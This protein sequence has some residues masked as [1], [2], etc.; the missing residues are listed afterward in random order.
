MEIAT[1]TPEERT[2][3]NILD[4]IIDVSKPI[5]FK[6]FVY[7]EFIQWNDELEELKTSLIKSDGQIDTNNKK[8]SKRYLEL[9]K[10][11]NDC[12]V[13]RDE[14]LI[15]TI[16]KVQEIATDEGYS[17]YKRDGGIYTYNGEFWI[18]I[19]SEEFT[20]FLSDFAEKIGVPP[21]YAKHHRFREELLK[22]F[23]LTHYL[24]YSL[25]DSDNVVINLSN[26]AFEITPFGQK[27][28]EF[29]KED[30]LKYK[31]SFDYNPS[32]KAPVFQ[33]YLD[34]VLPHEDVQRLF[35]ETIAYAFTR[36][37]AA[38]FEKVV[39]LYGQG[40]NGKS[41]ALDLIQDLI[42]K[43]NVSNFS[44]T[45]LTD[46]AGYT[47]AKIG[48]KLMNIAS[49]ISGNLENDHFKLLSSGE[50][51]EARNPYGEPFTIHDYC[52]FMFACNELPKSV[53]H[54]DGYHRR[55]LVIPFDV[56]IP[57]NERDVDL[58]NKIVNAGEL[59]GIFNLILEGLERILKQRKFSFCEQVDDV[60]A[61]FK[62]ESNSV[63]MFID[64][65]NLERSIT[66]YK[67]IAEL[68]PQYKRYCDS[69]GCKWFTRLNFKKE[70]IKNNVVVKKQS[71]G[72]VAYLNVKMEGEINDF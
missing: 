49:E 51:I 34:R 13:K 67:P 32:A 9:T 62:K 71:I 2:S 23:L 41:V 55:F 61:K 63:L 12:K 59:S 29:R 5:D 56:Q 27:L 31:L 8:G 17:L 28:R 46:K 24:R 30:F 44:L 14:Y 66:D 58:K 42:G 25:H 38:K 52:R 43:Q 37:S 40:A 68:Y 53:E 18:E 3:T 7:P 33:K 1:A 69:A 35:F 16:D 65:C 26:G 4:S 21:I 54:S 48:D 36:N 15:Y 6:S 47:R 45:S 70:L 10:K 57:K 20:H 19:G 60:S 64:E 50:P 22:Q 11:I 39:I 72:E